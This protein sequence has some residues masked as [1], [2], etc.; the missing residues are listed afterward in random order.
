MYPCFQKLEFFSFRRIENMA[1]FPG[2]LISKMETMAVFRILIVLS[3]SIA[4]T[5]AKPA[6]I[7]GW[8]I[9]LISR[10]YF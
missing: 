10:H 2:R 5:I 7:T 1:I 4:S 6:S 3:I 9:E 8:L